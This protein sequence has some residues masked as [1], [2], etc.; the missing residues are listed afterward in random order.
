MR[1]HQLPEAGTWVLVTLPQPYAPVD[2]PARYAVAEARDRHL[3]LRA[4]EGSARPDPPPGVPCVVRSVLTQG[5]SAICEAVV[6]ASGASV[7][8]VEAA[9]EPPRR[10]RQPCKVA[11]EVPDAGLGVIECVLEDLWA[12]GLR[13]HTGTVL[14]AVEHVFVTL[15]L[16]EMQPILAM[17]E[18][19][20]VHRWGDHDLL[21][22]L[23]FTL[24]APAH[25]ARLAA[26]LEWPVATPGE[27][28]VDLT[29]ANRDRAPLVRTVGKPPWPG[30]AM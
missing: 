4:E 16:S 18:V 22:A 30:P 19:R 20:E 12:D 1:H 11:I 14:T 10:Y 2:A 21:A 9:A 17:A 29:R 7:L 24:I 23:E 15:Q 3:A 27:T 8:M 26:L 13:V 25:R 28:V 5:R 6:V